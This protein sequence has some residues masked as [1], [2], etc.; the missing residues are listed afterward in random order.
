MPVIPQAEAAEIPWRPGYRVWRLA[1]AEQ[2]MACTAGMALLE[3]GAGAPLHVH[4]DA[5]EV[6]IV[7]E[8][9]ITCRLGEQACEAA[10]GDT[11]AIPAGTP[12]SFQALGPDGARIYSFQPSLGV[13]A[14]TRFLE[15]APA[16]SAASR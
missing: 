13:F 15:G 16:S 10:A 3:P 9:R 14:R 8:G 5:D 1:G 4:D 11:L 2:G 12:H 7:V 6:I